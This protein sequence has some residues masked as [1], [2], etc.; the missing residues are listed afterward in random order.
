L[1]VCYAVVHGQLVS[2]H[3]PLSMGNSVDTSILEPYSAALL[4]AVENASSG[5]IRRR[6]VEIAGDVEIDIETV[7]R[8]VVADMTC[9][10]FAL[11]QRDVD[12][13]RENPLHVLRRATRSANQALRE[14][15]VTAPARDEF[16]AKAM[17]DDVYAI[18]PLTWRDLSDDVHEAGI[19]WGAWKAATVLSRRRDEG[20]LS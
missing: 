10:L 15:G 20:K 18:G 4:S 12:D 6:L 2:I 7:V 13:Q 8:H 9:E 14:A 17:P 1:H 16:E 19:T 5:W 11:L 3:S